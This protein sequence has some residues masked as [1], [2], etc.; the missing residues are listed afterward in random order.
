MMS[1]KD[2]FE[3]LVLTQICIAYILIL[4][5]RKYVKFDVNVFHKVK[6]NVV[7]LDHKTDIVTH[8]TNI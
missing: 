8:V 5:K 7:I 4:T 2:D 1:N 6:T 3:L